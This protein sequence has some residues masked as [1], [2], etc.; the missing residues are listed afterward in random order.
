MTTRQIWFLGHFIAYAPLLLVC[1]LVGFFKITDR[2]VPSYI[3]P[4]AVICL[5]TFFI[6]IIIRDKPKKSSDQ[7]N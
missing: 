4:I 2:E 6:G 7:K 5:I 1:I 3:G